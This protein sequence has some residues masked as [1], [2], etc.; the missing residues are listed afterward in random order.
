[1]VPYDFA[2]AHL[3][4]ERERILK[5]T[6]FGHRRGAISVAVKGK[7]DNK[8]LEYRIH[9]VSTKQALGEGTGIPAAIGAIFMQQGK[10][11][12]KGVLP[13][14]GCMKPREF[15]DLWKPLMGVKDGEA[16]KSADTGIVIEK[17]DE[18]GKMTLLESL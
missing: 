16:G 12:G 4:K 3:L 5:E 9:G 2:V 10:I 14:E 7:K 1:M 8:D 13:P 15:L 17:I 18:T 6:N 11:R